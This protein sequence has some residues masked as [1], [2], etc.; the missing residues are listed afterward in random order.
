LHGCIY[1]LGTYQIALIGIGD[2]SY[3]TPYKS[4]TRTI[5]YYFY[6]SGI[7]CILTCVDYRA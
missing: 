1:T 6:L 5:S 3:P 7:N 2:I 4:K